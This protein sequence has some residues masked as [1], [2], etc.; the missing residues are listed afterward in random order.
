[1]CRYKKVRPPDMCEVF[2]CLCLSVTYSLSDN[3]LFF[4]PI[5]QLM[6]YTLYEQ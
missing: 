4:P 5:L 2:E 6:G 1:M 3:F